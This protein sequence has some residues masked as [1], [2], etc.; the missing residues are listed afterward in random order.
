M[1]S[2]KQE[3]LDISIKQEVL[4]IVKDRYKVLEII[5]SIRYNDQLEKVDQLLSKY[6]NHTFSSDERI[7]ILHHDTD[8]YISVEST[9]FTLYNLCM[10]LKKNQ[11]PH[12]FL[13]MFTNHYGIE[14]EVAHLSE[15]VCNSSPFKVVCTSQWYD[16]SDQQISNNSVPVIENL[17]CC[18]NG[19]NREH[20]L[21][22]LCYL[23]EH[24]LL[25]QGTISYH[26]K[27]I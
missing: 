13:I 19:V 21:L 20:R 25:S 22:T 14:K 2:I 4:D 26:F 5:D 6:I 12:E 1:L 16:Y 10:L 24:D 23:K 9:G 3:V 8:Y 15:Q 18:L 11:I 27:C 7:L 17:F